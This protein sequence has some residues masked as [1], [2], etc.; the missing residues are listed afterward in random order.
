MLQVTFGGRLF[1]LIPN[2]RS[3]VLCHLCLSTRH[4]FGLAV[5]AIFERLFG[6]L[7]GNFVIVVGLGR[8]YKPMPFLSYFSLIVTNKNVPAKWNFT[9]AWFLF[10]RVYIL[11]TFFFTFCTRET[12]ILRT[13]L[14]YSQ[15]KGQFKSQ[16]R[17][18][19]K[20]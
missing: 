18:L 19:R 17:N 7:K 6:K 5:L 13:L 12:F 16:T 11:Y 1:L 14:R 10:I 9:F 4:G 3:T 20:N 2:I 15:L 8:S